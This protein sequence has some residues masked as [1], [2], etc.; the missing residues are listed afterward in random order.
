[1]ISRAGFIG[2]R[3]II[4]SKVVVSSDAFLHIPRHL[5]FSGEGGMSTQPNATAERVGFKPH[6]PL[7]GNSISSY[8]GGLISIFGQKQTLQDNIRPGRDLPQVT[9]R[10][11]RKSPT[12]SGRCGDRLETFLETDSIP[13]AARAPTSMKMVV[14][15]YS[16]C[17]GRRPFDCDALSSRDSMTWSPPRTHDCCRSYGS[18][19]GSRLFLSR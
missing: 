10:S 19:T 13:W 12:V 17:D 18:S 2:T 5:R 9:V 14:Y 1:M 8:V 16:L 11:L 4:L 15:L 7:G 6:V 3:K